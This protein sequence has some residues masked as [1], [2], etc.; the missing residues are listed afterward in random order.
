MSTAKSWLAVRMRG[1]RWGLAW[2]KM[3]PAPRVSSSTSVGR[4]GVCWA[5]HHPEPSQNEGGQRKA[6][7]TADLVAE[8]FLV[9]ALVD[10]EVLTQ[11]LRQDD[12]VPVAGDA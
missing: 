8:E 6:Q 1:S 4:A 7:S 2:A 3:E 10:A 11:L 9:Q 12:D 5:D